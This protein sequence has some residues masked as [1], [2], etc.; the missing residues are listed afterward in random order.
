MKGKTVIFISHRLEEVL[1]ICDDILVLKDGCFQGVVDN[2]NKEA[3]STT[4]KE[5]IRMMTGTE[6]GLFFPDKK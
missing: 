2:S 6:K 3:A 5:I 1:S 4:R